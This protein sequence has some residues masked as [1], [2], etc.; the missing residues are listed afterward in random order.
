MKYFKLLVVTLLLC[1]C[2]QRGSEEL[3]LGL[4]WNLG[5]QMD[6][7]VNGVAMETSWGNRKATQQTFDSLKAV[8]FTSVRI[9]VTWLG[10]IGETP[11]YTIET[12]WMDRVAELVD[13]AENAGLYAIINIH[14]DGADSRHWLDIK[15]AA[16]DEAVNQRVKDQLHAMWT[17]IANRFKDKGNFLVFEV[18]N[19]VHDGKWGYGENRTDGG[20]QY[21]V[22]N[23]WNQVFVDAVRATGGKNGDRYLGVV[24]YCTSI[25][26]T[27]KHFRFPTDKA[28]NRQLLSV[29]YYDPVD[30]TL[31]NRVD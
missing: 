10:H 20:R 22:V 15:N 23:E 26:L 2:A 17:Q 13:Y 11:D 7:H 18:V 28:K 4:G 31:E 16:K 25:D 1:G 9:P 14:H 24:G 6:A 29:H 27:I 12:A 3:F 30:F 19:E 8:G 21:E 5:N